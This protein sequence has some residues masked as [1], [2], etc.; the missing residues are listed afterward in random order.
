MNP[1]ELINASKKSNQ[2]LIAVGAPIPGHICLKSCPVC[3]FRCDIHEPGI[4]EYRGIWHC[5]GR[6]D[7]HEIL[8]GRVRNN[9]LSVPL[10]CK[11]DNLLGLGDGNFKLRVKSYRETYTLCP[12]EKFSD[13]PAAAISIATGVL[14]HDDV[15]LTSAHYANK[16]N[17]GSLRFVFNFVMLDSLTANTQIKGVD[18]YSGEEILHREYD[19]DE[20]GSTGSDWALVKLDRKVKGRQSVILS[21]QSAF[22]EQPIYTIGYPCGLPLKYAPGAAI[23]KIEK[24]YFM[25]DL[26]VFDGNSGSPVFSAESHELLGIVARGDG[27]D[28]ELVDEGYISVIYP[29]PRKESYGSRCI[30]AKEFD[31]Y[32]VKT[33]MK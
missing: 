25:A 17:V 4:E 12:D 29:N 23:Q 6:N 13:Q 19:V 32:F 3:R 2:G 10:V 28:F 5:D 24:A 20:P 8:D 14:V 26:D 18:I 30:K 1:Q 22:I 15:V 21:K 11:K 16:R 31:E 27:T 9:A 33:G 7:F